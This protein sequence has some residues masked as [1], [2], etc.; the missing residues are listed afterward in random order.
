MKF[1]K[2]FKRFLSC[3]DKESDEKLKKMRY[4]A[5]KKLQN[6]LDVTRI[7]RKLRNFDAMTTFM[8]TER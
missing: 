3:C 2:T 4:L 8:L 6:E 1:K 5:E 7:I